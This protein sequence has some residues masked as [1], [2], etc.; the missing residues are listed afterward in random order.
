MICSHCPRLFFLGA[1]LL[2]WG[3]VLNAQTFQRL[4]TCPTLGCVFPP[5]Q[6]VLRALDPPAHVFLTG[7]EPTSWPG[8]SS[9]SVSKFMPPSTEVR[10]RAI[11]TRIPTSPSPSQDRVEDLRARRLTSRSRNRPWSVGTFPG[12]KVRS[13]LR[14]TIISPLTRCGTDR[15]AQDAKNASLVNV[16]AKAYR[17]VA[18]YQAGEYTATLT[19]N[20]GQ[21]TT[22]SWLVRD[23]ATARKTKNIVLFIG[24]CPTPVDNPA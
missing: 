16:A 5:D 9:T 18:L 7:A 3:S 13:L 4:G 20:N 12:M 14:P 23:L 15:F 24:V 2:S 17:R 10:Q 1:S 19:Y 22:A 6:Y 21:T 8:N 11:L